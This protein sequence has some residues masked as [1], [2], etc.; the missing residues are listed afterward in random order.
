MRI[1]KLGNLGER[2]ILDLCAAIESYTADCTLKDPGAFIFEGL[3]LTH[4]IERDLYVR[5]SNS[6][7]LMK[8]YAQRAGLEKEHKRIFELNIFE[9]LII[10]YFDPSVE[11]TIVNQKGDLLLVV[12][13][14][15]RF[16]YRFIKYF[17][18][19]FRYVRNSLSAQIYFVVGGI[20]FV[21]YLEFITA[22]LPASSY[23]YMVMSDMS[24]CPL[25]AKSGVPCTLPGL[26]A[27]LFGAVG[28][29]SNFLKPFRYLCL[30][31][32]LLSSHFS[33]LKP[34]VIMVVEGSSPID[35][36]VAE[37]G[38]Y[39]GVPTV[40]LQ[41]G[42]SPII[43]SGFKNLQFTSFYSWG[44]GF[45]RILS[46]ENPG[47]KFESVGNPALSNVIMGADESLIKI[48][49]IGFFL[50]VPCA[51]IGNEQF[52]EFIGLIIRT[53]E[54][55]PGIQVV[56][57]EH[58]NFR[59]QGAQRGKMLKLPNLRISNPQAEAI[60][61]VLSE[62]DF[63]VSIFSSVIMEA[64][65]AGK[66]S[67][68]CGIGGIRKY[69]PDLHSIGA[70]HEVNNIGDAEAFIDQVIRNP[71]RLQ[72]YSQKA[73]EIS[74]QYFDRLPSQKLISEKLLGFEFSK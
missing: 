55:Y 40:C 11:Y 17:F 67:L 20:K 8:I 70:C 63:I 42:W 33:R 49:C 27:Y 7:N 46:I 19:K 18:Y 65:Y 41:H 56:V 74:G 28:I 38:R 12:R 4:A 14:C 15:A 35:S 72:A 69:C 13:M 60:E 66:A 64:L 16:F 9:S 37:V 1:Y 21:K 62:S 5:C 52:D 68:I 59:M 39:Q 6:D 2:F 36:V 44:D 54:R 24:F 23:S 26:K 71:K 50:Q 53:A 3:N 29:R 34:A 47:Q 61:G 10:K 51:L 43:H 30:E 22:N 58:P 25:A 57:R 48:S 45:S 32:K 31:A 73:M